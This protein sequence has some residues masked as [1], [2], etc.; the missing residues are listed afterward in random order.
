MTKTCVKCGSTEFSSDGNCIQCKRAYDKAYRA[1]NKEKVADTKRQ[2]YLAK[3]EHYIQ[4]SRSR[5]ESK[6]D[7]ISEQAKAYRDRNKDKILHRKLVYRQ[8][9]KD[10]IAAQHKAHYEKNKASI[11]LR[12]KEYCEINKEAVMERRAAAYARNAEEA[13]AKAKAWFEANKERAKETRDRYFINNPEVYHNARVK[14]RKLQKGG[15]LSAGLIQLL[16]AEQGC[17]CPGCLK[18]L[19]DDFH[20]DHFNPLSK[21]GDHCDHNIQLLCPTCNLKKHATEAQAWIAIICQKPTM[22]SI[23]SYSSSS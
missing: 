8:N 4:K 19:A 11:S 13:K 5:Y 2:A 23:T 16:L 15:G 18:S 17:K 3:R 10:T 14:R 12:Q 22:T 9:N 7:G 1:A 20:L 21:G 6:K